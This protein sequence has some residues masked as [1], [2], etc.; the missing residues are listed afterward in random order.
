MGKSISE[1]DYSMQKRARAAF[2]LMNAD[3]KLKEMG[4]NSV[5]ISETK[6]DLL[7][8]IAYYCKG[9]MQPS[10]VK[11]IYARVGLYDPSEEECRQKITWTLNSKHIEGK[12]IDLV[13]VRNGNLWWNAPDAVWERMG[14]I[15]E[16]CGLQWGGRWDGDQKDRP[17]FQI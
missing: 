10:D 8:Q 7:V 16:E 14:E 9:R 17:H 6:R 11:K 5:A 1:L 4:C 2:D 12:A 13:P 3:E 15:G